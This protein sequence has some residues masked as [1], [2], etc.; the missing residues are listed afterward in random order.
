M[1]RGRWRTPGTGSLIVAVATGGAI[2]IAA[3]CGAKI[4]EVVPHIPRTFLFNKRI[5]R[6]VGLRIGVV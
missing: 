5:E 6:I 3:E 4:K 2:A 1:K